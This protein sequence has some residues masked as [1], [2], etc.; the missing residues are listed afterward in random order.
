MGTKTELISIRETTQLLHNE[1]LLTKKCLSMTGEIQCEAVLSL[2]EQFINTNKRNTLKDD[3]EKKI[4]SQLNVSNV[5]NAL[6]RR[7]KIFTT[8][9]HMITFYTVILN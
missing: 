8:S 2:Q 1:I 7:L 4:H 5:N 6:N 9:C 3:Y